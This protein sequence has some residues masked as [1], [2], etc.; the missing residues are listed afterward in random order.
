MNIFLT[1]FPHINRIFLNTFQSHK[2]SETDEISMHSDKFRK[3]TRMF[4]TKLS[5]SRE[6]LQ[7]LAILLKEFARWKF[8]LL[9]RVFIHK[10][11]IPSFNRFTLHVPLIVSSIHRA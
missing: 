3:S 11:V 2:N 4:H 7:S 9:R 10:T 6:H 8:Q 1:H 5:I